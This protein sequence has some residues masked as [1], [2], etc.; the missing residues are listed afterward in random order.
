MTSPNFAAILAIVTEMS[1]CLN[2]NI[3]KV[4]IAPLDSKLTADKA[5]ELA[6]LIAVISPT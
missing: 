4:H 6:K 2:E 1:R 5:M 3:A